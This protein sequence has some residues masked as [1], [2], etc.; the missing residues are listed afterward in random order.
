M[1]KDQGTKRGKSKRLGGT[2]KESHTGW[3]SPWVTESTLGPG[4][5]RGV[6][7]EEQVADPRQ[8]RSQNPGFLGIQGEASPG[9]RDDSS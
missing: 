1:G 7:A 4:E 2:W 5:K 6:Q 8:V 3:P 9:R